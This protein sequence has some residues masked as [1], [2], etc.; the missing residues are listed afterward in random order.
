MSA[1]VLPREWI[2]EAHLRSHREPR[3]HRGCRVASAS[4]FGTVESLVSIMS[5]RDIFQA[6][7]L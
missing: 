2:E 1:S 5:I 3:R 7:V 6:D 4:Q